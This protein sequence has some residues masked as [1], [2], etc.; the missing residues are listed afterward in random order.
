MLQAQYHQQ[1][2]VDKL[3]ELPPEALEEVA[4]FVLFI[5][6]KVNKVAQVSQLDS[7]ALILAE[8]HVL[9]HAEQAHLEQEFLDYERRFPKE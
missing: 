7:D 3:K 1:F 4:D 5:H 9:S 6:R 8:L 2:I